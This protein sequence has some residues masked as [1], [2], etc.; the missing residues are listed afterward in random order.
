MV[1]WNVIGGDSDP[2]GVTPEQVYYKVAH[3][4]A[5]VEKLKLAPIVLL[6]DG[7]QLSTIDVSP[8]SAI[9]KYV[10]NRESVVSALP[11]IIELLNQKGYTFAGVDENTPPSW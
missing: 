4:L 1:G 3:G 6:H 5:K 10:Q 7:A 9:G 11:R 2:Q 8:D